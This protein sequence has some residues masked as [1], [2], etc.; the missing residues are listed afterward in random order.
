MICETIAATWPA[1]AAF[2]V[3]LSALPITLAIGTRK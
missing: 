2:V 1:L 3:G